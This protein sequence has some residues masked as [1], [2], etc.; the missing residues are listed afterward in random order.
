VTSKLTCTLGF[1]KPGYE[2]S[3]SDLTAY[4]QEKFPKEDLRKVLL[5]E[6]DSL[7]IDID[8]CTAK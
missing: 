6:I 3:I 1:L 8:K 2:G 7:K 5:I 4:I